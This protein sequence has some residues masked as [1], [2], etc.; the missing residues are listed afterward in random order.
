[1]ASA[2][3]G[4]GFGDGGGF[5]TATQGGQAGSQDRRVSPP[6][7]APPRPLRARPLERAE[8]PA[9]PPG[10]ARAGAPGR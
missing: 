8:A 7:P 9:P 4:A 10:G 6:T 1:M 5:V 2:F 3:G